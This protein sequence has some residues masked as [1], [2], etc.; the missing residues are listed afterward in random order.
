MRTL[1]STC[2]PSA[3]GGPSLHS[4]AMA[5]LCPH[6]GTRGGCRR[7][8]KCSML[9]V[10]GDGSLAVS[11]AS[12]QD[13]MRDRDR[14]RTR[15][16]ERL[17]HVLAERGAVAS[18]T[19]MAFTRDEGPLKVRCLVSGGRLASARTFEVIN[20][21]VSEPGLRGKG[22]LPDDM[23]LDGARP[24]FFPW[25][26]CVRWLEGACGWVCEGGHCA[27]SLWRVLNEVGGGLQYVQY[28]LRG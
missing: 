23:R 26:V 11:S 9:H 7:G 6:Y 17:S 20:G 3:A 15:L 8:K 14:F 25:H 4:A 22:T 5:Q 13:P 16:H 1:S 18:V 27:L 10:T 28:G 24:L 19:G 2:V 12:A 21:E